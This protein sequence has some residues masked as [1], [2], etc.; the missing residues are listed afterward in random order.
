MEHSTGMTDRINQRREGNVWSRHFGLLQLDTIKP[1]IIQWYLPRYRVY[2]FIKL[3]VSGYTIVACIDGPLQEHPMG[4]S[5]HPGMEDNRVR[6]PTS[7]SRCVQMAGVARQR[8]S[9]DFLQ[10]E[11]YLA[12]G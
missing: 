4:V 9:L 6:S 12:G 11:S 10:F 1:D 3:Q 8:A 7:N 5:T 2:L